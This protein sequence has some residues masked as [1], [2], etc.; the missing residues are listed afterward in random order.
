MEKLKIIDVKQAHKRPSRRVYILSVNDLPLYRLAFEKHEDGRGWY[1]WV[2][3][4][5][6]Q[7]VA[8]IINPFFPMSDTAKSAIKNELGKT[9][10]FGVSGMTKEFLVEIY[11]FKNIE[12][13][14][15]Y[16]APFI[17]N[18]Y[19]LNETESFVWA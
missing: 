10:Y 14:K 8:S 2:G 7:G 3:I 12:D 15:I 11:E 18:K 17:K 1:G 5:K 6:G 13:A 4:N 16:F 19:P 9:R